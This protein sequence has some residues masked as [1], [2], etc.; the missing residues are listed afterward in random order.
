LAMTLSC[1]SIVAVSAG[2]L[3]GVAA[4]TGPALATPPS[5]FAVAPVANAPFGTINENTAGD[6]TGKWG[7][8][9]KTLDDS[10]VGADKVILQP[11]GTSGWHSHQ[12]PVFL[13]VTQ[14]TIEWMDSSLCTPKVLSAGQGVIEVAYRAHT[15]RNPAPS[16]GQAAEMIAVRIKPTS[17]VG[18]AFRIDEPLPNNC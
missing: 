14:G 17:V 13:I 15:S 18:P 9:L 7:M 16:G 3:V 5:G 4:L 6:K 10:D 1:T 2:A 8:I 12:S 11:Q